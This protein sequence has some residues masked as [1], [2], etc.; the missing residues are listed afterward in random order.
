MRVLKVG[1][2]ELSDPSFVTLL[3]QRVSEMRAETGQS[4][5]IVHGGGR[6]IAGM[7]AQLGLESIKVDGL[8]VTDSESLSVAE[9]VLSGHSNKILVKALL[10]VGLDAIGI[11]GVDGGLLRC[12]KKQHPTADLG[13]VGEIETVRVDLLQKIA[14]LGLTIVLSPISLGQDGLTYN[15]NADE[16]ASAV[17]LATN[18]EQLDFISNVPGVLRGDYVVPQLTAVETE[19]LIIEGIISGGMI[20]K[21]RAALQAINQG[22]AQARIVDLAG[23][24]TGGG[25]SFISDSVSGEQ[26]AS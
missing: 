11:S 12:H 15:V 19:Q 18:A 10:A 3:A 9:M 8:R 23:M 20:P 5:T 13:Y 21:V 17:A 7:Q 6:A 26:V 1:G 14:R 25:T 16:A 2:N 4:V 24:A 22:V